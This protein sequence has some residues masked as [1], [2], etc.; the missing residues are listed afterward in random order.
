MYVVWGLLYI[1]K[2][3]LGFSDRLWGHL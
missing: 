2:I 3:F 1:L